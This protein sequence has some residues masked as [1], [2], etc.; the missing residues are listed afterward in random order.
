MA[1]TY[2]K[3]ATRRFPGY[4]AN[5]AEL[6]VDM[7]DDYRMQLAGAD[8]PDSLRGVYADALVMDEF[9]FMAGEMWSG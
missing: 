5:E 4:S 9:A 8:N 2:L 7:L 6:R 1:W 3:D